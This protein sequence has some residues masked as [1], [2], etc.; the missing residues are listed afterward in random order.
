MKKPK[1]FKKLIAWYYR[2]VKYR[3]HPNLLLIT[4][5]SYQPSLFEQL[6]SGNGISAV[7]IGKGKYIEV[8]RLKN[9]S[10]FKNIPNIEL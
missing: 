4:F 5:D 1:Y 2:N 9:L 10:N 7:Y 8:T 6:Y 3:N